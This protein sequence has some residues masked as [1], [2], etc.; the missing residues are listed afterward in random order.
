MTLVEGIN[1]RTFP[2]AG[3]KL[4]HIFLAYIENK[5]GEPVVV[6]MSG[7]KKERNTTI[8]MISKTT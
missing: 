1:R 7:R 3:E 2:V 5:H 4:I 6:N 8:L